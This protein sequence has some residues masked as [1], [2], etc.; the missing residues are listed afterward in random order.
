MQTPRGKE[1]T[2]L[3][4]AKLITNERGE[5]ERYTKRKKSSPRSRTIGIP[6]MGKYALTELLNE[7][8]RRG[9]ESKDPSMKKTDRYKLENVNHTGFGHVCTT[10]GK[11]KGGSEQ[12]KR[13]EGSDLR[14]HWRG[15]PQERS[16]TGLQH[17]SPKGI[18]IFIPK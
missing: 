5:R 6:C 12:R 16:F 7:R 11:K 2:A 18:P 17:G 4:G 9:R 3:H 15:R 1:L 10:P 8:R 13:G 14:W